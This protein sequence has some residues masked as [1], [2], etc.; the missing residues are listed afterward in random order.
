MQP[1]DVTRPAHNPERTICEVH[2]EIYRAIVLKKTRKE[3][4]RLLQE[5]YRMGKK[6]DA[7]LRK[8]KNERP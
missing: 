3:L 8:Y 6:M 5:A 1:D 2:R 7:K 4:T